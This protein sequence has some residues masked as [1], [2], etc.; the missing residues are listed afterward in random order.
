MTPKQIQEII[1]NLSEPY[2]PGPNFG[3][4]TEAEIEDLMDIFDYNTPLYG[5]LE[6]GDETPL[7]IIILILIGLACF[8]IYLVL[9]R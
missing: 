8:L 7:Y 5:M 1:K 3:I 6:T 4:L 9:K 2:I